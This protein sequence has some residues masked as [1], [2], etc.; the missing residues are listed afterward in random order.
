MAA[1]LLFTAVPC[2]LTSTMRSL[3]GLLVCS[4]FF[5][6]AGNSFAV[7][8]AWNAAWFPRERQGFAFGAFGAGNL[9]A[10]ITKLAGPALIASLPALGWRLLP[11]VYAVLL[12]AMAAVV[13]FSAPRPER[14]PGVGRS[15][16]SMLAPL[17]LVR[18]WRFGLYYVVVFG[19]Y[20]ALSLWLPNYYRTVYGLSLARAALLTAFFIFP[21]ALLRAA[22]GWLSDRYGARP[23]TYTVFVAMLI[24]YVPL[25]AP[26]GA[27]GLDLG[28]EGFFALVLV[29]GA[30][31]GIGMGSVYRYIPEYFAKD[32][33][34]V[35][36]LVGT[37]GALGGFFMPISFGY[38][39]ALTGIPQSCFWVMLALV[40]WS[41]LWLHL[42]VT[43]M[44]RQRAPGALAVPG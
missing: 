33:G 20:V 5:G 30:A 8:I 18:V 37:L 22:G 10:S 1:L 13:W 27:L 39:D 42:V 36:G 7:G 24:A 29:L 38:L 41:F 32:V 40:A 21:A 14:R 31:M 17:R 3:E 25:A 19:A 15:L 35:G 28:L 6:V 26:R 11:L 34:A 16:A 4:F 2:A 23:V 44:K 9:G 12:A 43:G